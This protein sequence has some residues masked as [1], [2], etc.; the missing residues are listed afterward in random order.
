VAEPQAW[1]DLAG[2][3]G[4]VIE[5]LADLLDGQGWAN[6]YPRDLWQL[7]RLGYTAASAS[8]QLN[9][10]DIGQRWLVESAKRWLH[11]RLTVEEKSVNTVLADLLALRRLSGTCQPF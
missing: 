11:W 2:L 7:H 3:P 10:T 8:R 6:E 5:Q 4:F 1:S 9:F